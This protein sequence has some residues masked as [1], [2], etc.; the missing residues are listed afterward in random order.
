MAT[1]RP[2][3]AVPVAE[4]AAALLARPEVGPRAQ[5][6]AEQVAQ[7]LPGTA[8]VVYII[9]DLAN[10][11]WTRK[12]IAGEVTV[13]GTMEFGAGTLGT[14]AEN[15]KLVVFEGNDLQREDYA[16][17]DIRR[18]VTSLAY[19]PLLVDE[20]LFGAIELVS[21][22]QPIPEAMLEALNQVAEQ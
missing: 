12:A 8:V 2:A 21:Y 7:L 14:M 6:T 9:E 4:F 13:S 11:S 22:E 18:T 19:I 20:V 10:P 1:R 17:L 16:H 3:F 15:K 5:V